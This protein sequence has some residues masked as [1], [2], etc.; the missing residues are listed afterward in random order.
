MSCWRCS[1]CPKPCCRRCSIAP[2][3]FGATD[4]DLFGRGDP[5]LRHRRRPAGGADRPG[6]LRAGNGQI[7]LRHRL[8][9]L[10][11]YRPHAGRLQQP[12]PHDHRLPA[13]RQAQLRARRLDLCRRRRGAVAARRFA[14]R[15]KRRRSTGALA[16]AAD[17]TQDVSFWFR[18]SSAWARPIGGPT[19]AA[20]CSA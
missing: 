3:R 20:R 8:L 4:P 7:D 13:R 10:A 14:C 19:R 15:A 6:L 11:Q 12:A 5:D 1:A 18:P 9:R 16:A 17:P 2:P